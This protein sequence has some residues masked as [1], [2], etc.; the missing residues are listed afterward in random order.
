MEDRTLYQVGANALYDLPLGLS[1]LY[2]YLG[3]GVASTGFA[4]P[5][6][7]GPPATGGDSNGTRL[8]MNLLGGVRF[9]HV[10]LPVVRPFAQ[11]MLGVG[12]IDMFTIVGGVLFELAGGWGAATGRSGVAER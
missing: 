4:L 10:A 3:V 2:P 8:G 11:V 9:D 5:E 1:F 6:T 12:P 7:Q